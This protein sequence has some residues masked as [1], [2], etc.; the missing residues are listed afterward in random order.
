[1]FY[2][3]WL[4]VPATERFLNG[5]LEGLADTLIF[6]LEDA[7]KQ[8]DKANAR[9]RLVR[10]LKQA[11]EAQ[12]FIRI[13]DGEMGLE[14]LKVL[15]DCVYSGLVLPKTEDTAFAEKVSDLAPG[16]KL[17]ALVESTGGIINLEKIVSSPLFDGVAFGGEDYCREL[18]VETND[19]AMQYPRGCVVLYARH[20]HKICLDTI[21]LQYK[22]RSAFLQ[23]FQNA[24]SMGFDSK[25]LIHPAQADAV[26]EWEEQL[27][28]P[29]D[30][31]E[32]IERYEN[33]LTGL[34]RI[35]GRWYEKPHIERMKAILSQMETEHE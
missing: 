15:Q 20:Y 14:D 6:D 19:I 24:I 17:I 16:K 32:I 29:A 25:L 28:S 3:K 4:F 35:N 9:E 27:M 31:R 30:M 8:E 10:R 7:I 33:S 18:G 11:P 1:M 22:D 12:C 2:K 21:S 26:H 23:Q 13:N 34:V 5:R